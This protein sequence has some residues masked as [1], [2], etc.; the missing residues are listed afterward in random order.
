MKIQTRGITQADSNIQK[1]EL[2]ASGGKNTQKN[3]NKKNAKKKKNQKKKPKKMG[4]FTWSGW[5][6]KKKKKKCTACI[7]LVGDCRYKK[8]GEKKVCFSSSFLFPFFV[9]KK[10]SDT[11]CVQRKKNVQKNICI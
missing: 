11:D 8:G 10:R 6:V 2:F 3:S 9:L 5:N 7:G 4:G 1:V